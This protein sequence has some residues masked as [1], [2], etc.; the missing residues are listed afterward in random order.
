MQARNG[1]RVL[2][3]TFHLSVEGEAVTSKALELGECTMH[4][5]QW[6]LLVLSHTSNSVSLFVDEL[7]VAK[8]I[9][10]VLPF[11]DKIAL[12]MHC[13]IGADL[14]DNGDAGTAAVI[15][16]EHPALVGP[17]VPAV[18]LNLRS[19]MLFS[20]ALTNAD[21]VQLASLDSPAL[22]MLPLKSRVIRVSGSTD[23]RHSA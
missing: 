19:A 16:R 20:G 14:I 7:E 23:S 6:H 4:S 11:G 18:E 1:I 22:A 12:P 21:V 13:F 5:R 8:A 15:E 9:P 17:R 10:S 2:F 3:L